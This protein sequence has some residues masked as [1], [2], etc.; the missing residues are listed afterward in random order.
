MAGYIGR[1]GTWSGG[2]RSAA[3][4]LCAV[5]LVAVVMPLVALQIPDAIAWA[6]PPRVTA[7]GPTMVTSLLRAT[8]LALPVMAAATPLGA[9]A[10]RRLR[11]GPVLL[12]GLLVL[13]VADMLGDTAGTVLEIGADRILHGLGA[14]VAMV[15][16]VAVIA[17]QRQAQR[18]L[19][20]AWAA[21]TVAGLVVAP[22]L[23]RHLVSSGGWHAALQPYPWLTGTALGLAALY[24]GLAEGT[25]VAAARSAFP[26][27][28]R[29]QLALLAAPVAGMCAIT[30]AVTYRGDKAMA[31][32]AIADVIA[33]S[34]VTAIMARAAAGR[35][36]VV[37]AVTGFTLPAAAALIPAAAQSG[38]AA[39]AAALC[40]AALLYVPLAAGLSAAL[41]SSLRATGAAGA[42]A[43]VVLL[44]AGVMAGSLAVGSMQLNALTG[45]RTAQAVRDALVTATGHWALVAAV[46]T[47]V[48]AL[49]LAG[50]AVTARRGARR[51]ARKSAGGSPPPSASSPPPPSGD[52]PSHG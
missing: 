7:A 16:M 3:A 34:G 47:A 18:S 46:V 36:A 11:A 45:A 2:A 41:T 20:G 42:M 23:M 25:V 26:V 24:A 13:A 30:V 27:A 50:T 5:A 1:A 21:V 37:C 32:A 4:G 9:L 29:S 44:L 14:G 10:V 33:L 31:A 12:V 38:S 51:S 17:E 22:G 28:E 52:T 6:L 40:G 48:V 35:L 49:T 43:G 19:A 8:D 15:A 39:L